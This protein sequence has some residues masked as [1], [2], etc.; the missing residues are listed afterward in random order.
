[1]SSIIGVPS[2]RVSNIFVQQ[3]MLSEVQQDQTELYKTQMQ[4]A[5]GKRFQSPSA[6]PLSAARVCDLQRQIEMKTQFQASIEANNTFLSM[7]DST[8][9]SVFDLVTQ[10]R[11]TGLTGVDVT[12]SDAQ[13]QGLAQQVQQTIGEMINLSNYQVGGR[14]LFAGS[15]TN[16]CPYEETENGYIEFCGNNETL[17]SYCDQGLV[18]DTNVSGGE[19]FGGFSSKTEGTTDVDPNLTFDTKLADLHAG[20]G[21]EPGSIEIGNGKNYRIVDL[22]SCE[23]IGDVTQTI[24]EN[25]PEGSRIELEIRPDGLAMR[26]IPTAAYA[27]NFSINEV[28]G[29]T[30]AADLGILAEKGVGSAWLEGTDLDPQL[31][32]TTQIEETF[33][34]KAQVYYHSESDDAGLIFRAKDN[35]A[36]SNWIQVVIEDTAPAAGMETASYSD[37]TRTLTLSI[38][39]NETTAGLAFEAVNGLAGCPIEAVL[40]PIT[41]RNGGK[42]AISVTP[43]GDPLITMRGTGNELNQT[44][45]LQIFNDGQTY[46]IDFEKASTYEDM[47]NTLNASKA[48]VFAEIND[49]HTGINIHSC[50]SGCDFAVG[51]NGGNTAEALGIRTFAGTTELAGMNYGTGVQIAEDAEDFTFTIADGTEIAVDLAHKLDANGLPVAVEDGGGPAQNGSKMFS[52]S[53]IAPRRTGFLDSADQPVLDGYGR[54]VPQGPGPTERRRERDRVGRP[55]FWG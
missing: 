1:M 54:P 17:Q 44:S 3:K 38:K 20:D 53:S 37:E 45:G 23:T 16:V 12:C 13:R 6:D 2:G 34:S 29:G 19:I 55:E 40:D 28:A 33:G 5:S 43:P 31:T 11:G 8:L 30:T 14:Y 26:L 39:A 27:M 52:I 36:G 24:K 35:G 51:E 7:T 25:A 10:A 47:L 9:M 22:S 49:D 15:Q 41:E 48:K 46:E 50:V 18:F 4:I 42:G 21:V 32:K